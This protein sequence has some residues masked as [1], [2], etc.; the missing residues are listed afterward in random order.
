M[1]ATGLLLLNPG[2]AAL[3]MICTG[4]V[5]ARGV[6]TASKRVDLRHQRTK[7]YKFPRCVATHPGPYRQLTLAEYGAVNRF[8]DT[9]FPEE[10][11]QWWL[12]PNDRPMP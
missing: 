9:T 3:P 7:L 1:R 11:D 10:F 4:G 6:I 12:S 2:A 8:V 5:L